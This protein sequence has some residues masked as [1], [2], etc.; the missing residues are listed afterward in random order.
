M[1]LYTW[2]EVED[3]GMPSGQQAFASQR[4]ISYVLLS[5]ILTVFSCIVLYSILYDN[6]FLQLGPNDTLHFVYIAIDT[7]PKWVGLTT[8]VVVTQILKVLADEIVS[9]WIINTIMDHKSTE[10]TTSAMTVTYTEAQCICQTYYMFAASVKFITISITISQIDLVTVLIV[11]D[12][13]VSIYTTH[14]FLR[15]KMPVAILA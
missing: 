7:W 8:F 15:A 3:T 13:I 6:N 12:I 5:W 11:T 2:H 1:S 4:H 14:H 10:V 9:P